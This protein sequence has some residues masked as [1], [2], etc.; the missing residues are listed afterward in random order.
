[1]RKQGRG[2]QILEYN[3][4]WKDTQLAGD[5]AF[6]WGFISGATRPAPQAEIVRYRFKALR[7]LR[8]EAG[9]WKVFRT[10]WN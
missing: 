10:I 7:V 3:Q 8:K 2:S 4:E 5:Y 9:Q 1:M 6:Q